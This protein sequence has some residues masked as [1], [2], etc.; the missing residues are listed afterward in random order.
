[1]LVLTGTMEAIW[2]VF[3]RRKVCA[4]LAKLGSG[5]NNNKFKWS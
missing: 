5:I 4:D 2:S 3:E 1:M